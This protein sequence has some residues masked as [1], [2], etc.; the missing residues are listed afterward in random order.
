MISFAHFFDPYVLFLLGAA[1]NIEQTREG[2][3]ITPLNFLLQ[4]VDGN[5]VLSYQSPWEATMLLL[6]I[7]VLYSLLLVGLIVIAAYILSWSIG[8]FTAL[9]L[10]ALPGVAATLGLW[11]NITYSPDTLVLRGTGM[12]GSPWGMFPLVLMGLLTGWS[13]VLILSDLLDFKDKFRHY[14]RH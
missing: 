8:S 6:G 14:Y 7:L 5:M 9:L 11:P 3:R 10:L 1:Y 4:G 12:L 2:L 13:V